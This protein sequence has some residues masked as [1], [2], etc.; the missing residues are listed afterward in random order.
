MLYD[1]D[2]QPPRR[3]PDG[4]PATPPYSPTGSQI[5]NSGIYLQ[6]QAQAEQAYQTALAT[7]AQKKSETFRNYGFLENGQVDPNNNYGQIQNL[8]RNQAGA[9]NQEDYSLLSRGIHG[10]L[11]GQE[12]SALKGAEGAQNLDLQQG[13]TGAMNDLANQRTGAESEHSTALLNAQQEAMAQALQDN[14]F[15]PAEAEAALPNHKK[16]RRHIVNVLRHKAK[17]KKGGRH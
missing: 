6:R 1:G 3:N 10:G 11:A 7:I 4:T 5:P 13:Y 15:T 2:P 14:N 16:A 9:A 17:N 8:W 12:H